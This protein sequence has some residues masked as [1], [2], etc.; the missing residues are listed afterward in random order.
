MLTSEITFVITTF[1]SDNIINNILKNIPKNSEII[2]CENSEN[3]KLKVQLEEKY[4]NLKCIVNKNIG[5]GA[6]NNLGIKFAKNP[7][8]F[9]VNPDV[10]LNKEKLAQIINILEKEK[11]FAIAAPY[12][13][14]EFEKF[15]NSEI[16]TDREEVKGFAMIINKSNCKDFYFDENF[17]LYLEEIDLCKRLKKTG[18]RIINIKVFL[19]HIGGGSHSN[20][21]KEMEL[22]R[23]WHW[24]W[25]RF[26]F[27][28]KH[29]GYIFSLLVFFP[30]FLLTFIK[31][32][33]SVNKFIRHKNKMRFLGLFNSM[34]LRKSFYRPNLK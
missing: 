33:F 12:E 20:F 31:F 27:S 17:F 19:D 23:N 25:S 24:M 18:K 2:V 7:Y 14:S 34:L 4:E 32:F 21:K 9:I 28:K 30:L 29:K 5:Y 1:N 10:A 3:Y 16:V 8:V 13:T 15:K 11:N 6:A 22:S 26:Y